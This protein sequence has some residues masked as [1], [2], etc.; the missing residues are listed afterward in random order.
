MRVSKLAKYSVILSLIPALYYTFFPGKIILVTLI[1]A[2][3]ILIGILLFLNKKIHK[4]FDG[5]FYMNLFIIYNIIV[6]VRGLFDATSIQDW[7]VMFGNKIPLFLVVHFA[8]FIASDIS[9]IIAVIR[10]FL[11]YGLLVGFVMFFF[12]N[13]PG[14]LGFTRTI[15]PISFMIFLFPY[16]NKKLRIFIFSVAM[17]SFLSDLEN[18]SNLLNILIASIILLISFYKKAYVVIKGFKYTRS[19]MLF[20]PVFFLGLGLSG[21]FNIFLVGDYFDNYYNQE[22]KGTSKDVLVDSRTDI[23]KDVFFQL[24]N[25]EAFLFGLGASGKTK[26][27]LT[28]YG[29]YDIIY[30]EGRRD[31]ES[32]MLNYFQ[33]GGLV[34]GLVYFLLFVKASYYG[35]YKSRNWLCKMIGLWVVYKGVFSFIEDPIFFGIG[36]IFVFFPISVCFNKEFRLLNDFELKVIF[37]NIFNR[38]KRLK[39]IS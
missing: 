7:I 33:W 31:T 22:N 36:P 9:S 18:R 16:V 28:D 17:F 39:V 14:P 38:K 27:F 26:T 1:C 30:K 3:P 29:D 15:A 8:I 21:T 25:D 12:P 35:I 5:L 10:S 6:L 4:K 34:G 11:I 2:Y 19:I 20:F 13:D 23:Y 37:T 32:G 24:K